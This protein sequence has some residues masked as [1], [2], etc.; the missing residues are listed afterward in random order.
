MPTGW[1][2]AAILAGLVL[3]AGAVSSAANPEAPKPGSTGLSLEG[4]LSR[5]VFRALVR[6]EFSV[7]LSNQAATLVLVR[8]DDVP[9]SADGRQFVVIFEG[10]PD[11]KLGEG[12]YRLTHARAGTTDLYLRPTPSAGGH[13]YYEAPFSL[14]PP[15]VEI[16]A[17][18]RS[19]KRYERPLYEPRR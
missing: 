1:R 18:A 14:L 15:N 11:L 16:P 12:L 13:S 10:S 5:D 19:L 2:F 7:L 3:L 17:P 4:P 8:V 6:E 9:P